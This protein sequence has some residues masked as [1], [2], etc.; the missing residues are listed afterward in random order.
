MIP[1]GIVATKIGL[2]ATYD[3]RY[4]GDGIELK[5]QGGLTPYVKG[6]R[7]HQKNRDQTHGKF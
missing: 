7:G 3:I 6:R 4:T 5:G 2:L 1:S